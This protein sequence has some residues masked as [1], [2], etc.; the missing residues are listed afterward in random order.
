MS[1]QMHTMP[2]KKVTGFTL[3]ELMVTLSVAAI[4]AA[5]AT[6]SFKNLIRSTTLTTISN[7][8]VAAMATARSES[9]K[10]GVP[11]SINAIN[12]DWSDGWE[13]NQLQADGTVCNDTQNCLIRHFGA[14]KSGYSVQLTDSVTDPEL[15]YLP[16][17][18]IKSSG[19]IER[20][21]QICADDFSQ[22]KHVTVTE[23]GRTEST[24]ISEACSP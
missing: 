13:V 14:V 10:L 22:Q 19:T 3:I 21:Y 16:S 8:L 12:G 11:V 15:V 4:L 17:G 24:T 18:L 9:I 23:T 7:Q 20:K 1:Q 6:P 5:L 2:R